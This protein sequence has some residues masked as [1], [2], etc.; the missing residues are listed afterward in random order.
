MA[1][2]SQVFN[3]FRRIACSGTW[4]GLPIQKNPWDLMVLQE[5]IYETKPDVIIETGTFWGGSGLFMAGILES[6]GK[7]IVI[8]IDLANK[9]SRHPRMVCIEGDSISAE[10]QEKLHSLV[11]P[12]HSVMVDLDSGHYLEHVR[13]E[14]E[15]Y[16]PLVTPGNYLVVE[17]TNTEGPS[18]AVLEFLLTNKQFSVESRERFRLTFF[19]GGWLR[20][21]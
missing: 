9:K 16:A 14:L 21:N 3:D 5:V 18:E 17:D 6:I 10:V 4:L 12:S 1:I 2:A 13:K 11:K 20:R 19:P 7:G 15:L 8:S